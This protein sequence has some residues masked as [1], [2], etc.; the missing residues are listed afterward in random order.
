VLVIGGIE[1]PGRQQR[2]VGS[3]LPLGGADR[4][5]RRQQLLGIILDRAMR[6]REN[7]SGKSRIITSR[8]SSM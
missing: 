5:Q 8:F 4:A 3:R 1:L 2:D 6:W 7:S